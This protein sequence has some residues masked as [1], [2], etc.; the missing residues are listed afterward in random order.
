MLPHP[1]LWWGACFVIG[2]AVG[3]V[4]M[5]LEDLYQVERAEANGYAK[6]WAVATQLIRDKSRR[7]RDGEPGLV[8]VPPTSPKKPAA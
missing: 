3:A 1:D 8:S 4:V 7:E 6:G 5:H 2:A